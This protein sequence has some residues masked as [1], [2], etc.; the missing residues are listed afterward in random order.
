MS[1]HNKWSKIK[2]AKEP[3]YAVL[4]CTAATACGTLP[5]SALRSEYVIPLLLSIEKH[6]TFRF[7]QYMHN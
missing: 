7:F 1:G 6:L 3:A 5:K 4:P 2:N